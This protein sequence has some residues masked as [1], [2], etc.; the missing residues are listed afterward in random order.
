MSEMI[1]RVAD[2]IEK[3]DEPPSD[4]SHTQCYSPPTARRDR[5]LARAR[6]A[7]EA[8]LAP[9][10]ETIERVA[11]AMFENENSPANSQFADTKKYFGWDGDGFNGHYLWRAKARVALKAALS[12]P[13]TDKT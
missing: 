4:G 13:D 7:I 1:E 11:R 2:A 9:D 10:E 8:M 6:A 5:N 3:E 12:T